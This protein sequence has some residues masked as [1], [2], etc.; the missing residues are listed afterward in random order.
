M[1]TQNPDTFDF[2]DTPQVPKRPSRRP[3]KELDTTPLAADVEPIVRQ[4]DTA[5]AAVEE[6]V[7]ETVLEESAAS[8]ASSAASSGS[9]ANPIELDEAERPSIP[10][11]RPRKEV[12]PPAATFMPTPVT[13]ATFDEPS[14]SV[15]I[16]KKGM[17]TEEAAA[18]EKKQEEQEL[19]R[20]TPS[21]PSRPSRRP[22]EDKPAAPARRPAVSSTPSYDASTPFQPIEPQVPERPQRPSSRPSKQASEE[23]L[24]ERISKDK[25][26]GIEVGLG[27]MDRPVAKGVPKD[28]MALLHESL[29]DVRDPS[30]VRSGPPL[31]AAVPKDDI[32]L[33]LE[34]QKGG[35]AG[36]DSEFPTSDARDVT[37][38]R[39]DDDDEEYAHRKVPLDAVALEEKRRS[40]EHVS[41]EQARDLK[42]VESRDVGLDDVALEHL[43]QQEKTAAEPVI[44][45]RPSRPAKRPTASTSVESLSTARE[46]TLDLSKDEP[47]LLE[48]EEE[49]IIEDVEEEPVVGVG[50]AEREIEQEIEKDTPKESSQPSTLREV[51]VGGSEGI[52]SKDVSE[53]IPIEKKLKEVSGD[54]KPFEDS[55]DAQEFSKDSKDT[56]DTTPLKTHSKE[57]E[58]DAPKDEEESTSSIGAAAAAATA[59]IAAAAAGI[60]AAV[61]G[62]KEDAKD[63]PSRSPVIPTRPKPVS[64]TG[65]N[66]SSK[67]PLIPPRPMRRPDKNASSSSLG[68]GLSSDNLVLEEPSKPDEE[69]SKTDLSDTKP[70]AKEAKLDESSIKSEESVSKDLKPDQSDAKPDESTAKDAKTDES[71][72]SSKIPPAKPAKR[73]PPVKPKPKIGA[74]F[75]A[76]LEEK[77]KEFKPKP[78]VPV[79]S[80]K[81]SALA[82]G[83]D[84]MFGAGGGPMVFGAPMPKK[85]VEDEE[86]VSE[87]GGAGVSH[88]LPPIGVDKEKEDEGKKEE[89]SSSSRRGRVKGPKRK[90]PSSAVSP[91]SS[92]VIADVWEL[93]P[94]KVKELS[95]DIKEKSHDLKENVHEKAEDAK[96]K[97]HELESD[98][99]AKSRDLEHKIAAHH[100]HL[101]DESH[102]DSSDDDFEDAREHVVHDGKYIKTVGV[103]KSEQARDHATEPHVTESKPHVTESSDSHVTLDK[104]LSSALETSLNPST[105]VDVVRDGASST[106]LGEKKEEP[107]IPVRPSRP[108]RRPVHEDADVESPTDT[109]SVEKHTPISHES[110]IGNPDNLLYSSNDDVSRFSTS[111]EPKFSVS[112]PDVIKS[113]THHSPYEPGSISEPDVIKS[114]THHM[115][116]QP[117]SEAV[118]VEAA[119]EGE[120]D[121]KQSVG[122]IIG[123]YLDGDEKGDPQETIE[124]E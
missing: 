41:G 102:V 94:E 88:D 58:K 5:V 45:A 71:T 121:R 124:E 19:E 52:A 54:F 76:A 75:Q 33:M 93:V 2:E 28:D 24:E 13:E 26:I 20:A 37:E 35:V 69:D 68:V 66:L 101:H 60:A 51:L 3:I 73:P 105:H 21:I 123:G 99:S 120:S 92:S 84:G 79:R 22:T 63:S 85:E 65:S 53:D 50:A 48:G 74:A 80:N 42:E 46:A 98:L 108:A 122:S 10:A 87:A 103:P 110:D 1:L 34:G 59:G 96:E 39:D 18:F 118:D 57:V 32:A 36:D 31:K 6:T 55:K 30:E 117:F 112:E 119:V 62:D 17:T 8:V 86:E 16:P 4:H 25:D 95:H 61:T 116:S 106:D 70:V 11:R 44:P 89:S 67:S 107:V 9:R 56:S 38:S 47:V 43:K 27:P 23:A 49:E 97:V 72:D 15:K 114:A 78:R 64:R 12:T 100:A 90:L 40:L 81:I 83:L 7:P 91:W 115:K 29:S 109:K 14:F 82:K 104:P 113:G 111:A 77:D